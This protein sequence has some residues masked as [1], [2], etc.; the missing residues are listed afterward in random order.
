MGTGVLRG[1]MMKRPRRKVNH[2][3]PSSATI[4]NEWNYIPTLLTRLHGVDEDNVTF[5]YLTKWVNQGDSVGVATLYGLD[6]PG[7][8]C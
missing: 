3:L 4:K 2:L 6:R 7:I 8:E 1:G 5:L